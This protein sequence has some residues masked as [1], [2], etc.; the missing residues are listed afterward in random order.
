M[1]SVDN[2]IVNM[3][4]NNTQFN[5]GAADSQ[6]ALETLEKTIASSAQ[7]KGLQSMAGQVDGVTSRFSAMQV[8]GVAAIATIASKATSM[9]LNL[10]KKFTI[11]PL[12]D[13]FQEYQT[14]LSSIQTIMANTGK[15][16]KQV[17][18]ALDQLNEYSDQTIYN[19]GEMA[20]NVGTFTAAGV[21]LKTSVASI[22]GIANLAA[23][24]GSNSQQ[25]SMAMYQLSQAIAAGKVGLQDWNSVVNAG[26][27][28]KIFQSALARTAQN[29][30]DLSKNA[31]AL[32]GP[33][34]KLT[35]DGQSF[36]ESISAAGGGESWL[37]SDVLV[38][39]LKQI[40]GGYSKAQLMAKGYSEEQAKGII[41]MQEDAFNAATQIKT[42]PQL[43]GVI[44]ESIGSTW[45]GVFRTILGDFEQSKHLWSEAGL[46][47]IGPQ[48]FMTKA[49]NGL[50]DFVKEWAKLGG[51]E[52]VIMG[53]QRTYKTLRRIF[54]NLGQAW[55]DVFPP[56][57]NNA[58]FK[59]S[60]GFNEL[61]KK[62]RPTKDTMDSLQDIFGG[63][64]AL[65]HI[66][67]TVV[68]AFSTV[69]MGFLSGLYDGTRESQSGTLD[70]LAA[71]GRILKAFD[72]WL[73]EG[74]KVR[75]VLTEIGH[76]GGVVLSPLLKA[77]GLIGSAFAA[78]ARGEGLSGFMDPIHE[79][80]SIF[81]TFVSNVLGG[82]AELTAPFDKVSGFIDNLKNK[83]DGL[84]T[85]LPDVSS[86]FGGSESGKATKALA[87]GADRIS[88]S[89]DKVSK[90]TD[91]V[92][93]AVT[94]AY[95]AF[96]GGGADSAIEKTSKMGS[97]A[98]D[99]GLDFENFK[100][101]I[102]LGLTRLKTAFDYV[103]SGLG[104]VKD[105]VVALFGDMDALE[106][107]SLVNTVFAGGLLL[108]LRSFVKF[109]QDFV[110]RTGSIR[111]SI[112]Y[113]FGSIGD[114][115]RGLSDAF[116][117][118][119]KAEL[120]KSYAIALGVLALSLIA[121]SFVPAD[122]LKV[123]I[124]AL[125]TVIGLMVGSL[126]ALSKIEGE[127]SMTATAAAML[128]LSAAM[129]N[130]AI[131]V[132]VFGSMDMKTLKQGIS[133][134]A[135]TLAILMLAFLGFSKIT[136]SI[137]GMAASI[138]IIALAM[139]A[140][141][142]AVLM[143]GSQDLETLKKG[144]GAMAIGLGILV[145]A[146]LGLDRI[147]GSVEGLAG[148]IFVMAA[149]MVVLAAAVGAFGKMKPK[150]LEQGLKA[151]AIGLGMMVVAIM[152]LSSNS[153]G[154]LAGATAMLIMAAALNALISVILILGAT[155]WQVVAQGIGLFAAA[156]AVL[157]A[158]GAI[159][160]IPVVTAGL[161]ILATTVVLLGAG[162][163]LAGAGMAAF[164]AGFAVM[165]AAGVA[166]VAVMVA[167]FQAFMA[168]L[169]S[170][171]V[172]I[173]AAFVAFL[174]VLAA[175]SPKI[176]ASMGTIFRNMIGVITDA[177]P[178]IGKLF[179]KLIDT[180]IKVLTNSIP[181][182][183]EL[184][185]TI[186]DEFINSAEE[187]V[188][189]I[190]ES[191]VNLIANF[192]TEIGNGLPDIIDAGTRLVIRFIRGMGK[193]SAQIADA[194]GQTI[195]DVL[196]GIDAAVE[197]YSSQIRNAG[198]RIAGHLID[199]MT[200]GL[201]GKVSS[202]VGGAVSAGL[203]AIGLGRA[204]ANRQDIRSSA[205]QAVNTALGLANANLSEGN[206]ATGRTARAASTAQARADS[207]QTA[208]DIQARAAQAADRKAAQAEAKA[209][210]KN[211][212]R[213]SKKRAGK[214]RREANKS[215]NKAAKM[216]SGADAKQAA[217]DRAAEALSWQQSFAEADSQGKGEM[218]EERANDY[219]LRAQKLMQQAN[220]QAAAATKLRGK[221][222]IAMQRAAEASARA[223]KEQA[224]KAI[225]ADKE[226][227][228]YYAQ[229]VQERID[230]LNAEKTAR[231][232]ED[233]F[234]KADTKTKSEMMT[235]RA[236][237]S[238]KAAKAAQ[239][240]ADD[241]LKQAIYYKDRDAEKAQRYLEIAE[242]AA[243]TA[244]DAED[245]AK[246]EREQ[247][248][249]LAQQAASEGA[250]G[251]GASTGGS[252]P[253]IQ[254]SK[255]ILENAA[256]AMDSF[257]ASQEAA[258]ALAASEP[259]VVQFEQTINSPEAVTASEV[260][261]HTKNLISTADTNMSAPA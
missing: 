123:G 259:R 174:K 143:F 232:E 82:L 7:S 166:G 32:E 96:T 216:Q 9:G 72:N 11:S 19:F 218:W 68:S 142:V 114:S 97:A 223:A 181:K 117:D 85:G 251:G 26:M 129:I 92:K 1:S 14:G 141:A 77:I 134:L 66:G 234:D 248:A 57:Q 40:S 190:A 219:A 195:L 224:D 52:E 119:T 118:R 8:A 37:T 240:I 60:E 167:A 164:G 132:G 135:A 202:G 250:T 130:L 252:L 236:E 148:S 71:V 152:L 51:R 206:S 93:G 256:S 188:P 235:A 73:T 207:A 49:Q 215:A 46:A 41:K 172:Q 162:L 87:D 160:G 5:K 28:G 147:K 150:T 227:D 23:L 238:E 229:N 59:V 144:L 54:V 15:S 53:F 109:M 3:Q 108:S 17:N 115:V 13:G 25:A 253:I 43:L 75:E 243:Q 18:H 169:P 47:I 170:I 101:T 146:M 196:N 246:Q 151:V 104:K 124:A 168:L 226:A 31:V 231:A 233:K 136:G 22:K 156:L 58:L 180:G 209:G 65:L 182:Y 67:Y 158:A 175:A 178:E 179:Q 204:M 27:G 257:T 122:K 55:R 157:L 45:A 99:S 245:R 173:A 48:G 76:V 38:E 89:F 102:S 193:A 2:R 213:A 74:V 139:Q 103:A 149:A 84:R 35:I 126:F 24:S 106:L 10:A 241:N 183:I 163:F 95:A 110:S 137:E 221:E 161:G 133:A 261:R 81:L 63:V 228:K 78:L 107:A 211:A 217:A 249:Q 205:Q 214:L 185:F 200:G 34:K 30:G 116:A 125:T 56:A 127:F 138:F 64:F 186:I 155:P 203:D 12:M 165:A 69:F 154:A 20:K 171:A 194:T 88:T 140:L 237:A 242:Q 29:M 244:D 50:T 239:Q 36:R 159:A 191:A 16:V 128:I 247:A 153:A 192:L 189:N 98:V 91:K 6:K 111:G 254:L 83:L 222:R 184:G 220:A 120:I 225:A 201:A 187:H 176:R 61:S 208:A 94:G 113:M 121:L 62:L 145:A 33:M 255:T 260:Y 44:Q 258:T 79:A 4:F 100:E 230:Q 212:S 198:L 105:F 39:T 197:K 21:D 86:V 90:S 42:L 210:K 177:I 199:G 70:L 80:Q 131:A 112:S